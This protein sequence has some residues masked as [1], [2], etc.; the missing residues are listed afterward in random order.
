MIIEFDGKDHIY[1]VNGDI[2]TTSITELLRKHG[3][4]PSY[5]G[6]SESVL[7]EAA[8]RGTQVH[9]DLANVLNRADYE[10]LTEQGKQFKKWVEE[11]LDCGVGEQLL[12]YKDGYFTIGGT[13]DVVAFGKDGKRIIADHK[14]TS[15][16]NREYVSWQVSLEDYFLRRIGKSTIN[17]KKLNWNKTDKFYCFHYNP[18]TYEM[19][20]YELEKVPDEELE[21][22]IDCE[23]KGEIYQRPLLVV[24]NELQLKVEEAEQT[25]IAK[26]KEYKQAQEN[27]KALREK[28]CAVMEKQKIK[29]WET[30]D[31]KVT[32]VDRYVRQSVDSKKLK[33]E[34]PQAYTVC[35]KFTEV[36]PSVK[37]TFKNDEDE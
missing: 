3:L 4:A 31:L 18:K 36:K 22:L 6:V 23:R 15:A 8:I 13:A 19:K 21:K 25:L 34:Y 17:G 35:Q 14:N 11:N 10:P 30:N 32:Y 1:S 37:V 33:E 27:A 28:L 26:E 24:D 7:K 29:S 12:G 9:E 5:D 16:F 2:A 20:V